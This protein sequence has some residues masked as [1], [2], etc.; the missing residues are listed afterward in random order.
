TGI[1]LH[2]DGFSV[3][4]AELLLGDVAVVALQLLLGAQLNAEVRRLALAA[5]AVLARAVG[6]LVHRGF[7][8]A[9]DVFAKTAVKLELRS[10]TLG[11]DN[12]SNRFCYVQSSEHAI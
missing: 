4:L 8:T 7:R 9:P 2:A 11:H 3:G 1:A 10:Q 5:L 6:A 12:P